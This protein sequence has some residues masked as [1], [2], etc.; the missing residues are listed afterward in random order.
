MKKLIFVLVVLSISTV[1][2]ADCKNIISK[3]N[4]NHSTNFLID[5]PEECG[6]IKTAF[7][8]SDEY[9]NRKRVPNLGYPENGAPPYF[10]YDTAAVLGKNDPND[11]LIEIWISPDKQLLVGFATM[12]GN[13]R[14]YAFLF[15]K[16]ESN[17]IKGYSDHDKDG[18]YDYPFTLDMRGNR[19]IPLLPVWKV[20]NALTRGKFDYTEYKKKQRGT[21]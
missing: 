10:Y 9:T 5:T 6:W 18:I 15:K 16:V 4:L 13:E 21:K 3:A 1:V 7:S 14:P 17:L 12:I 20:K 19:P 8:Y 11:T 2:F